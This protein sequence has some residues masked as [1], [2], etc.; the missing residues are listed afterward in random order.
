MKGTPM[1]PTVQELFNT[2]IQLPLDMQSLLAEKLVGHVETH[3]DPS[4]E[5]L[6]LT[7]TKRR[8]AEINSGNVSSVDG[9]EALHRVRKSVAVQ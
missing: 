1:A 6:H 9:I 4:L 3:I 2:A 8:R 5:K 7:L